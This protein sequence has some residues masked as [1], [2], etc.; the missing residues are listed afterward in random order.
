M[1]AEAVVSG[2]QLGENRMRQQARTDTFCLVSLLQKHIRPQTH[3]LWSW[4]AAISSI[5]DPLPLRTDVCYLHRE[6]RLSSYYYDDH[7]R[8]DTTSSPPHCGT[9]HPPY[10][11][12]GVVWSHTPTGAAAAAAAGLKLNLLACSQPA[13]SGSGWTGV[14][15]LSG[16]HR[17][18]KP[19]EYPCAGEARTDHRG[20]LPSSSRQK[21]KSH[22][23][24][25]AVEEEG[26]RVFQSV[27]IKIGKKRKNPYPQSERLNGWLHINGP[28]RQ[29]VRAGDR[30][31]G[32]LVCLVPA[33]I[34]IQITRFP[35]SAQTVT[36]KW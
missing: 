27:K 7:Y 5:Y 3:L 34:V 12:G 6:C 14:W 1:Q 19:L 16:E 31:G 26:L 2:L 35:L 24:S 21:G 30:R 17:C 25:M 32:G 15:S 4:N 20:G 10:R 13:S 11:V 8:T 28:S 33:V 9:D 23:G 29:A 22:G 18:A 36:H